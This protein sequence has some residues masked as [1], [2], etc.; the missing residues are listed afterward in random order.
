MFLRNVSRFLPN[1]MALQSRIS[2]GY[3][4]SGRS[5]KV[6]TWLHVLSSYEFTQLRH[7]VVKALCCKAAG[8]GFKSR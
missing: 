1:Y 8:R 7:A 6:T 2:D 4:H 3:V 5:G